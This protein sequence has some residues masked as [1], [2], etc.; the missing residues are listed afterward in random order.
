VYA[1]HLIGVGTHNSLMTSNNIAKL[2]VDW[3][4]LNRK[5]EVIH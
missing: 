5:V 3:L 1:Q 2:V 4:L